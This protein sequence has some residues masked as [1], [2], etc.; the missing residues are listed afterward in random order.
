M[1]GQARATVSGVTIECVVGDIARQEGFDAV[2]NA[3]NA[4]FTDGCSRTSRAAGSRAGSVA[5]PG[6]Y[7]SSFSACV[8]SIRRARVVGTRPE[9]CV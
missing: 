5:C 7:A 1:S 2:V 9:T 8:G 3:A 4:E 6:R